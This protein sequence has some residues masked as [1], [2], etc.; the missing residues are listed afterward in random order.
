[1]IYGVWIFR[2]DSG[3]LLFRYTTHNSRKSDSDDVLSAGFLSALLKF[4]S[5]YFDEHRIDVLVMGESKISYHIPQDSNIAV[6]LH[7]SVR[8][9][10][11]LL[12]KCLKFVHTAFISQFAQAENSRFDGRIDPYDEFAHSYMPIVEQFQETRLKV[13]L[14]GLDQAG[15]TSLVSVAV[16]EAPKAQYRPTMAVRIS[17]KAVRN[18]KLQFWDLGG[19]ESIRELWWDFAIGS[20]GF[21][22]VVDS[23]DM[24]RI[25]EAKNAFQEAVSYLDIPYLIVANKQDLFGA[26]SPV[27]LAKVFE[28]PEERVIP[29]SCILETGI[30]EL[31]DAIVR[32]F[33][34]RESVETPVWGFSLPQRMALLYD[35]CLSSFSHETL[36]HA[37]LFLLKGVREILGFDN[38][39]LFLLD[40]HEYLRPIAV[41]GPNKAEILPVL[42]HF[43]IE[44]HSGVIGE[45][46]RSGSGMIMSEPSIDPRTI[47]L[48]GMDDLIV[49]Q[50]L[51]PIIGKNNEVFGVL[52][53]SSKDKHAFSPD[54]QATLAIATRTISQ[55]IEVFARISL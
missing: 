8:H 1:M 9:D 44:K 38:S 22:F 49:A 3:V 14:L 53:A 45:V 19:Q 31:L 17:E 10:N 33:L 21:L 24:E 42:E 34:H 39:I 4:A 2:V 50:I 43:R 47:F 6:I 51:S 16:E 12:K 11:H 41:E 35:T 40:D 46:F 54:H 20:A 27:Y 28:A 55:L 32:V 29:T 18:I 37:L 25:N 5:V 26:K 52:H 48:P 23:S 36:D 7:S 15:K 13:V 30:Q